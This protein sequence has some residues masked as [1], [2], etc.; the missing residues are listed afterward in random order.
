MREAI[1]H[2]TSSREEILLGYAGS[3]AARAIRY[4]EEAIRL[5]TLLKSIR[6]ARF[7]KIKV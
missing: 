4:Y 3:E 1:A 2:T 7:A 5:T 6:S